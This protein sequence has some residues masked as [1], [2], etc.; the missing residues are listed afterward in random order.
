MRHADIVYVDE[1]VCLCILT[2]VT[3]VR[4]RTSFF[5]MHDCCIHASCE[6]CLRWWVYM[7][8]YTDLR[9]QRSCT[10]FLLVMQDCCIY[11]PCRHSLR[12]WVYML[13]Y[14]DLRDQRS[15]TYFLFVMQDC[16]IHVPCRHWIRR[17]VYRLMYIDQRYQ[18]LSTYVLCA[19]RTLF[20]LM[21]IYAYVNWSTLLYTCVMRN[22]LRWWVHTFMYTDLRDQRSCTYFLLVMQDCCI[23]APSRHWL[24][25]WVYMLLYTDLRNQRSCTYFLF[26]MQDCYIHVPCRHWIRRLVYMLM[27]IDVYWS[28]IPTF[29]YAR[30]VR[31]ADID[32]YI[33]LC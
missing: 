1:Y 20:T 27:Y 15:C 25:R 28:T 9:D 12:R 24:R 19:M 29:E 17:L 5:V 14:T 4:V 26:V 16:Y 2:Y 11:A 10:Y 30:L 33:C 7:F 18:R 31:H 23:Y 13:L 8:M 3:N 21:S 32:E 22:C 6:H